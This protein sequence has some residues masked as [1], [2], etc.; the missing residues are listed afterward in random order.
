[1]AK[2]LVCKLSDLQ[3]G[4]MKAIQVEGH[5]EIVLTNVDGNIY[6]M[7]GLCNHAGG[8]L[9]DGILEDTTIICPW[10]ASKW[11]IKTGKCTEFAI[12][13]DPEPVYPV[14]TSGDD[15]YIEI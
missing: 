6:A 14:T 11:D 4:S 2:V 12:D 10:H 5:D 7:R 13:L 15:I 9:A 3:P 8:P 1:M